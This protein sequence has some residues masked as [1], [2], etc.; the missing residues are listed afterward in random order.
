MESTFYAQGLNFIAASSLWS[1]FAGSAA[2]NMGA[3]GDQAKQAL[4]IRRSPFSVPSPI[5]R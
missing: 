2:V 4:R 1:F 5:F 3:Q